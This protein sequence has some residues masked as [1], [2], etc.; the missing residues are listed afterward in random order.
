M[1]ALPPTPVP[2]L[3]SSTAVLVE[4]LGLVPHP[5]GGF[6]REVFRSGAEPMTTRG[7]T[8]LSA[9]RLV[10][11]DRL[12]QRPDGDPRR[13]EL[14]SIYWLPTR[15]SP[16]LRLTINCSDHVHYY[17]GGDAFEYT[18]LDPKTGSLSTTVLGPDLVSG[19]QPQVCVQGGWLKCGRLLAGAAGYSLIGEAVAPGFDFYDFTWVSP[20]RLEAACRAPDQLG[21]LRPF[22][23]HEAGQLQDQASCVADTDQ[24][25]E[26]DAQRAARATA[27]LQLR[28]P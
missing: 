12:G 18:T 2:S 7:Q 17:H 28:G 9:P 10:T 22:L 13:N 5:E 11:T 25:Y 4:R 20:E 23:H 16:T 3:P 15:A 24:Y 1:A 21:K 26:D 19:Q 8:D 14:T 6:F 27:R